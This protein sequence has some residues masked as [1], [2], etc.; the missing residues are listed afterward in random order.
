VISG[1]SYDSSSDLRLH[2]GL[3]PSTSVERMEIQ[4]P[5]GKKEEVTI[6]AI[7]KFYTVAEG[8]GRVQEK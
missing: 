1:G 8:Q 7:D 4:W 5:S 3:G 2:F 6:T